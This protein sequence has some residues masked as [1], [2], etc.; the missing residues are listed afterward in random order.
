MVKQLITLCLICCASLCLAD[1]YIIATGENGTEEVYVADRL[2]YTNWLS[3]AVLWMPFPAEKLAGTYYDYSIQDNDFA[4]STVGFRPAFTNGFGGAYAFTTGDH[5]VN[6]NTTGA[7][8]RSQSVWFYIA[9][10][11]TGF[12]R[13]FQHGVNRSSV[14]IWSGDDDIV[15]Y[16][17]AVAAD[18]GVVPSEGAWHFLA[19]ARSTSPSLLMVYLDGVEIYSATPTAGAAALGELT[20]GATTGGSQFWEG[21]LDDFRYYDRAISS[22]E[23]FNIYMDEPLIANGGKR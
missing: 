3:D 13:M 18:T 14:L 16:Y 6:T 5:I 11:S 10:A 20:V 2:V 4:Q 23:Q 7:T 22:N 19:M 17:N 9:P 15:A 21:M 12:R 1:D 8:L